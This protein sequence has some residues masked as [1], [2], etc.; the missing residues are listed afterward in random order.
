[1]TLRSSSKDKNNQANKPFSNKSSLESTEDSSS[2]MT[3]LLETQEKDPALIARSTP[4]NIFKKSK[5]L[6]NEDP[7]V[8][9]E[10]DAT[11]SAMD[12]GTSQPAAELQIQ[13]FQ[14]MPLHLFTSFKYWMIK[15]IE[16]LNNAAFSG[17]SEENITSADKMENVSEN[18]AE[19]S[20]NKVIF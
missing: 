10:Q 5:R 2:Q 6:K 4:R 19:L 11:K 1:M 8:K 3:D 14:N 18:P 17:S 15:R 9:E 13:P 12:L 20:N 7:D 16:L